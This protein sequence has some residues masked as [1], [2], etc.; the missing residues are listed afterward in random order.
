MKTILSLPVNFIRAIFTAIGSFFTAVFNAIVGFFKYISR[1]ITAFFNALKRP[2]QTSVLSLRGLIIALIVGV[3]IA[4]VAVM[5]QPF[6]LSDY[7]NADKTLFLATF[8]VVAFFGMLI[9]QFVLPM[10]L[11]GLYNEY[12]WTIGKQI[13]HLLLMVLVVTVLMI[14]Y[15]QQFGIA[16]FDIVMDTLKVL[17]ISILPIIILTFIQEKSLANGF[18]SKAENINTSLGKM[19]VAKT[20]PMPMIF[21]E[22]KKLS[23]LPNQLICAEISKDNTTFYYQNFMG[24][25]KTNVAMSANSVEKELSGHTQFVRLHQNYIVNTHAIHD[26]NGSARGYDLKVARLEKE[27]AVAKKFNSNLEGL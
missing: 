9:C 10:I 11:S 19:K 23:L 21:G 24:V 18:T 3:I 16:Q 7:Q 1:Q 15:A 17:A 5:V 4:A 12:R 8:G 26:V 20:Q 6:G 25:E 27:I 22:G 14:V 2:M 13:I